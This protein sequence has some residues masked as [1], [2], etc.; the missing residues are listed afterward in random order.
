[1]DPFPP[2]A[3]AVRSGSRATVASVFQNFGRPRESDAE[4]S[5]GAAR[6]EGVAADA[7]RDGRERDVYEEGLAAGRAAA[8]QDLGRSADA[9]AAAVEE[10]VRFRTGLLDRY[11]RELLELAVGIARKVVQRELAEHPEHWLGMIR[12]AVRHALDRERIRIRVGTVLHHYLL[13]HLPGLRGMLEDV[14]ELD[15]VEDGTLAENGC[16]LE[17]HYGDLDLSID[18]QMSAIRAAL[19]QAE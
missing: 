16:V 5:G 9:F 6:E 8:E 12:E 18:S 4:D 14:K 15:L 19:T 13:E 2:V 7:E 3:E 17:T 10:V 1:M 11:Q